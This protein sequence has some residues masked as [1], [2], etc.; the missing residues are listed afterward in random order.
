MRAGTSRESWEEEY[1]GDDP[2]DQLCI[3]VGI[4]YSYER[5]KDD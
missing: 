5:N 2:Y 4:N 1:Y 3:R